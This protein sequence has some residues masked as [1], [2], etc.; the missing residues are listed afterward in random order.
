MCDWGQV[1]PDC[2]PIVS[3]QLHQ[4]TAHHS[5]S[6]R[7]AT[8]PAQLMQVD[9]LSLET[10]FDR[11]HFRRSRQDGE[12]FHDLVIRGHFTSFADKA[13]WGIFNQQSPRFV[14]RFIRGLR[15]SRVNS[16]RHGPAVSSP[17]SDLE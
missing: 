14:M 7:P 17:Q 12:Q 1:L 16:N 13:G 9:T 3:R 5:R 6:M 15:L 8:W 10:F 2:R 4:E 11:R